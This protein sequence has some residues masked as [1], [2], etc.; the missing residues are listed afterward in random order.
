MPSCTH[1]ST[2]AVLM[3]LGTITAP[4]AAQGSGS[5]PIVP[6]SDHG[7]AV[8]APSARA[9]PRAG[10]ITLDGRLDE[11][12]WTTIEP[13]T[14][15]RQSQP[16]DG[17]P[18]TQRTEVRFLFD[19]DAIY[20]GARM[21]DTE[22]A[23]GIRSRLVRRDQ[24]TEADRLDIIFDTY[25]N[26][27]GRTMF[28]V[29]PSGVR[30]DAGQ[31][32]ENTDPSW[33][34]VWEART[35]IDAEGW[36]AE[37]RIPFSQLRFPRDSGQTWGLQVWR[38]ASRTNEISMWS[39]WTRTESGGPQQFG[40][41]EGLAVSRGARRLEIMPYVV[42]R[43]QLLRPGDAGNPFFQ[44][45]R[46][47]ARFGGDLKY[48]MTSNLTLDATI[49][50]DF[51]QVE[52]DPAQVNLSAFETFFEER[53]PFFIEGSG[54]FGFGGFNC[55]F[56]SNA[57]P[58]SLFY[59]RRIGRSP[60]GQVPT[61]TTYS[62]LPDA[63][64]ILGAA[65]VSGRT[66]G[67]WTIGMLDAITSREHAQT[68]TGPAT[69]SHEV[70]P[71]TNYFVGRVRKDLSHG[72]LTLGTIATS[73]YRATDQASLRARLPQHAEAV[74]FDWNARW[75]N[76]TWSFFGNMA[77]TNVSGEASAIDRL[78]RPVLPAARSDPGIEWVLLER[79]RPHR[80]QPARLGRLRPTRQG[81]R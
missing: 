64:T 50:P 65:K 23:A 68:L 1:S 40:H 26:H 7:H 30:Y 69:G 21:F 44:Q 73:V 45:R 13:L 11:A 38:I 17:E 36:T 43:G 80:H 16:N 33:D 4:L 28:S 2:A 25:H 71:L 15:F 67:G 20:I 62:Q 31:A 3:I 63:S 76:R 12:F 18:A 10:A 49:N 70:E 35:A 72:N 53:R 55:M 6:E 24:E 42:G 14:G 52:V 41:L 75:K 61:G 79:L 51:G 57:A 47:D 32:S 39:Y 81:C 29:N 46:A 58:M 22:G 27:L 48:L 77:V 60:Q 66:G 74:G 8:A 56:C 19:D 59:S 37:L 54:V 78:Q 9:M 5:F 34:P